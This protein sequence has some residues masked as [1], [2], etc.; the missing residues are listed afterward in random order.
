MVGRGDA[1]DAFAEFPLFR[2]EVFAN[3]EASLGDRAAM[4]LRRLD[5]PSALCAKPNHIESFFDMQ[6]RG[7]SLRVGAIVIVHAVGYVGMLLNLAQEQSRADGVRGACGNEN[8]VVFLGECDQ[9]IFRGAVFDGALET[10]ARNAWVQADHY[11]GSGLR[12]KRI[13]HLRFAAATAF[14]LVLAHVIVTDA[15]VRKACLR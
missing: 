5:F 11:F 9:A 3:G 15:P 14:R 12:A 8:G 4:N 13:P 2:S 1:L 10:F 7:G 6:A